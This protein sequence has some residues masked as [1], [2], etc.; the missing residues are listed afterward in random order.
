MVRTAPLHTRTRRLVTGVTGRSCRPARC[1]ADGRPARSVDRQ[2]RPGSD[3]PRCCPPTPPGLRP[4]GPRTRMAASVE[5]R[6]VPAAHRRRTQA[7]GVPARSPDPDRRPVR[8]TRVPRTGPAGADSVTDRRP[9]RRLGT[10]TRAS[11]EVSSA[12]SRATILRRS[13]VQAPCG[14]NDGG[15]RVAEDRLV[16]RDGPTRASAGTPQARRARAVGDRLRPSSS[17]RQAV[18]LR[19]QCRGL[20]ARGPATSMRV[21]LV[22]QPFSA[23]IMTHMQRY[24]GVS[25]A[26]TLTVVD[27]GDVASGTTASAGKPGASASLS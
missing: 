25:M 14:R 17:A 22:R 13:S 26:N 1:W 3:S 24:C 20:R 23:G 6:P 16:H 7:S 10:A 12:R 8:S 19:K 11:G 4:S 5:P 15:V 9:P 21:V 27:L 18:N 2:H